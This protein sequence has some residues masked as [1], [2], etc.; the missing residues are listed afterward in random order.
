M[1]EQNKKEKVEHMSE[2]MNELFDMILKSNGSE[3]F[4]STVRLLQTKTKTR[5]LMFKVVRKVVEPS[6]PN[7]NLVSECTVIIN[8]FKEHLLEFALTNNIKI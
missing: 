8:S 3:D 2:F 7:L 4:K 5:D 1:N 6:E